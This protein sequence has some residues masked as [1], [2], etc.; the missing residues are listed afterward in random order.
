MATETRMVK[1]SKEV[2]VCD[3]CKKHK[4]IIIASEF[5]AMTP[6]TKPRE[7]KGDLCESCAD[8]VVRR[9]GAP[10]KRKPKAAGGKAFVA[11]VLG[12]ST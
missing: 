6:G 11:G 4:G 12:A 3:R 2:R 1:E 8:M 7:W 10:N 5:K 9:L